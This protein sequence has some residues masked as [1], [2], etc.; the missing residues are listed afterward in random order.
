M[1]GQSCAITYP[2]ASQ[3]IHK[4]SVNLIKV[5][6]LKT[7]VRACGPKHTPSFMVGMKAESFAMI[8]FTPRST[9]I[10][11][12]FACLYSFDDLLQVSYLS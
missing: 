8:T 5:D 4:G 2:F 10:N 3:P 11:I 6:Y 12:S 1:G 9:D 7:G